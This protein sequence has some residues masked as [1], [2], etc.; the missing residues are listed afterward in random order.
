M[1]TPDDQQE[2]DTEISTVIQN[3]YYYYEVDGHTFVSRKDA[4]HHVV[5]KIAERYRQQ[6]RA[7]NP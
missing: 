5:K 7:E 2:I 6:R 3:G 4:E 1:R